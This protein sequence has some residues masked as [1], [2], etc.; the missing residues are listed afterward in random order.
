MIKTI[1]EDA[2][3][4]WQKAHELNRQMVHDLFT[5]DFDQLTS[6]WINYDAIAFYEQWMWI[7]TT[8]YKTNGYNSSLPIKRIWSDGSDDEFINALEEIGRA[9]V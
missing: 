8:F 5:K 4:E 9:H 6:K 3:L 2:E 7:H 1:K